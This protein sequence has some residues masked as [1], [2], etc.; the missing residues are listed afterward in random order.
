MNCDV[1]IPIRLSNTRLPQKAMKLVNGKPII[2]YLIERLLFTKKIRNIII[3]T[4]TMESDDPLVNLLEKFNVKIFR[5][6]ENDIL[7]RYL[8]AARKFE[9][10]FIVSVDGDDV[11]TDIDYVDE[12]V[13]IYQKTNYDYIDMIEFPF[14]IASVG[15]K[16]SALEKICKLK[17]TENT[18]TGY[19]LFFTE[20]DIFNVYQL[21]PKKEIVFPRNL[22]LTLDYEEDLA[23]AKEIFKNLGNDF[24]LQDILELFTKNPKLLKITSNLEE[25]YK[26]HWNKNLADTSIKN[27]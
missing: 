25:K 17:Q 12:I 4:T 26:E 14:G 16:T 22:R 6:N 21:K 9:T 27:I 2:T 24:H 5:G 8:D 10:D 7:I 15:I 1:F 3:C 11:Y 19:R 13:S 23:L 18:D 20:N